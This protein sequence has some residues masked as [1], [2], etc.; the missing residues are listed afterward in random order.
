MLIKEVDNGTV[1]YEDLNNS[2]P[3]SIDKY[4][5]GEKCDIAIIDGR[6]RVKCAKQVYK[7][8]SGRG[9]VIFDDSHREYYHDGIEFYKEKGF[10]SITF[11]GIKPTGRGTDQTTLLY[12]DGNCLGI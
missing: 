3:N 6:K 5:K 4:M 1:H 7:Y 12:R 10:R 9:I 11:K 8:L 2:Y